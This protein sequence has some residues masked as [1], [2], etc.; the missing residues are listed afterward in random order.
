M[1]NV[2]WSDEEEVLNFFNGD[3]ED[4]D[5]FDGFNFVV[6]DFGDINVL[7]YVFM[8]DFVFGND[9]DNDVD[10][11]EGWSR[12]DF[13]LLIVLFIREEKLNV[14]MENDEFLSFFKLF[15]SDEFMEIFV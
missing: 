1:A 3:S 15:V 8:S 2:D 7:I 10:F 9:R 5:D 14:E 12:I 11:E 13:A 4:E 6:F